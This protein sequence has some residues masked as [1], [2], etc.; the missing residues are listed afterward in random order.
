MTPEREKALEQLLKSTGYIMLCM[1]DTFAFAT[2]EGEP[3]APKD[4]ELMVPII[5]RY[6]HNAFVAYAAVK[7]NVEPISCRCNHINEQYYAAKKEIEEIKKS[8]EYFML[9]A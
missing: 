8:N 4:F 5:A 6:G 1:N 2:A 7:N 3:M 9:L